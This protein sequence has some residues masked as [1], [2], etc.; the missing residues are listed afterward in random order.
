LSRGCRACAADGLRCWRRGACS[1]DERWREVGCGA[2]CCMGRWRLGRR[3]APVAGMAGSLDFN[4]NPGPAGFPDFASEM[5]EPR[6]CP[7][8][9]KPPTEAPLAE[10]TPTASRYF[11]VQVSKESG[12]QRRYRTAHASLF[13]AGFPPAG[14][15]I[16]RIFRFCAS[17]RSSRCKETSVPI[18]VPMLFQNQSQLGHMNSNASLR[19]IDLMCWCIVTYSNQ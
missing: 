15:H 9:W 18:F 6:I 4:F 5:W 10:V 1:W 14:C 16:A 17:C 3:D 8:A 19:G 2:V 7:P 11:S 13:S 12:G